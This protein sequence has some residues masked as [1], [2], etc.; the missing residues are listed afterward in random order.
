MTFLSTGSFTLT[1][2]IS[3]RKRRAWSGTT[4]VHDRDGFARCARIWDIIEKVPDEDATLG[5]LAIY[6]KLLPVRGL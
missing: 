2:Y 6:F 1:V 5:D 3:E 4:Y